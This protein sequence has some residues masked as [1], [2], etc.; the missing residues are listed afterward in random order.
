MVCGACGDDLVPDAEPLAAAP[1][2]AV[3]AHPDDD[4]L[5]MQPDLG[6]LVAA[7]TGLTVVYVT[8]G[9]GAGGLAT[10]ERRYA[11][12]RE[13]YAYAAGVPSAAWA[14]GTIELAG[15]PAEHCRLPDARLSLVFLGYPDGGKAGEAPASL[16]HLWEGTV[17]DAQTIARHPTS[18]DQPGLIAAVAEVIA[19]T[20]PTTL[21]TLDLAGTHGRDHADHRLA[22]ALA[23][24]ATATA[25]SPA[26]VIAYRGYATDLEPVNVLG[27]LYERAA[28]MLARYHAC[29]SECGT[30]GEPCPTLPEAHATWLRRRYAIGLRPR[31]RGVLRTGDRCATLTADGT[32]ALGDCATAPS[33]ELAPDRTLRVGERC[34]EP[35]R[36]GELIARGAC[37]SAA[38]R[39]WFLD[40]EGHLWLATTPPPQPI[41]RAHLP[42]L[43]VVDDRPQVALCGAAYA[44]TWT[45]APV[46][47]SAPR[48]LPAL[49]GRAVRLGDLTGDRRADLCFVDAGGLQC[50]PGDGA[51]GFAAPVR[52]DHAVAALAV[53]PES[54]LLGD[55][56][57]DR[58]ADACGRDAGGITCA[59][60]ASGFSV[61]RWSPLFAHPGGADATDRSLAATDADGDGLAD[62]CGLDAAGVVC[63]TSR[64][65]PLTRSR[66]P[67]L[68]V[69]LWAGDLDGDR[70]ADWCAATD[71]RISCSVDAHRALTTDGVPWSFAL[72]GSLEPAPGST[73]VAALGDV[74]GDDRA[75]LCAIVDRQIVC[76][77]SQGRGFGP[78]TTLATLPPGDPA[79]AL[80]LGD[81]DGDGTTDACVDDGATIRCVRR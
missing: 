79:S 72:G 61:Q 27:P 5:F 6:D 7:R 71:N 26:T 65:G 24:V 34:I 67:G 50:A 60:A 19:T 56:D 11:G 18:Y 55:I 75:D 77:R 28:N 48:M 73:A 63:A 9:N 33:W 51:G 41:D 3:V 15:H 14:C 30:C 1:D 47:T 17:T 74:D 76:A 20:A 37:A 31:A 8:A 81:L 22:G 80:W 57:G 10:A 29:A 16:R 35:L 53:E 46:P 32:I 44:P 13:A 45:L 70:R 69:P 4:L 58:R 59:R 68:D 54:L 49:P 39:A 42:C 21:H 36:S 38:A 66:W 2:L 40:D 43:A 25:T 62:V 64:T 23:L 52:I 12:V 78:L